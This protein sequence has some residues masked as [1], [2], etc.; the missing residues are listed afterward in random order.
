MSNACATHSKFSFSLILLASNYHEVIIHPVTNTGQDVASLKHAVPNHIEMHRRVDRYEQRMVPV[1]MLDYGAFASFAPKY[2]SNSANISFE[3]TY[4]AKITKQAEREADKRRSQELYGNS[5][6]D[7]T[8]LKDQGLDA[9]AILESVNG[10]E[11]K[12]REEK[13]DMATVIEQ[14]AH[15]LK[16]LADLQDERFNQ[17]DPTNKPV[18]KEEL[19]IGKNWLFR[20]CVLYYINSLVTATLL[21]QRLHEV[22]GQVTPSDLVHSNAIEIAMQRIPAKDAV[23]RGTLPPTKL[24]AFSAGNSDGASLSNSQSNVG[25]R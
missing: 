23:Y 10:L 18:G 14:N 24:F 6:I 12:D 8:W 11:P 5:T 17:R 13:E 7:T 22:V 21:Q 2:D 1:E 25:S 4:L 19:R 3:S 9:E 20:T 16:R 15:L